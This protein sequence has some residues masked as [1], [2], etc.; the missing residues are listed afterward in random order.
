MLKAAGGDL[1][2]LEMTI[3]KKFE[4]TRSAQIEGEYVTQLDLEGKGWD[5]DMIATSKQ[6]AHSRGYLRTSEIH[7]KE[8]WKLPLKESFAYGRA[9]TESGEVHGT[10]DVE[11]RDIYIIQYKVFNMSTKIMGCTMISIGFW[12]RTQMACCSN[13]TSLPPLPWSGWVL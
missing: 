4:S 8:E 11:D 12:G 9:E 6:W 7:G 3:K 5:A 10:M 1:S 2:K 13:S